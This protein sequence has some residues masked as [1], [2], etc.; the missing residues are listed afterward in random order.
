MEKKMI[1]GIV[2]IMFVVVALCG[3]QAGQVSNNYE[4][5]FQSNVVQLVNFSLELEKDRLNVITSATV[6]GRITSVVDRILNFE[7]TASFYDKNNNLLGN[8][9]IRIEGLQPMGKPGSSTSFPPPYLSYTAADVS[10]V[11]HVKLYAYEI[12]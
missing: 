8:K 9:T 5:I 1:G 3:C 11:D 6:N 12:T 4:D 10:V 7:I 2:G